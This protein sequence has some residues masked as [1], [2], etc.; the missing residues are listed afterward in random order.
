[1]NLNTFKHLGIVLLAGI[2]VSSCNTKQKSP[3]TGW[4]Y[5]DKK[6]GGFQVFPGLDQVAG[7]GL[8]YVEG[9][10]FVMGNNEQ[11]LTY[12]FDNIERRMTV[13]SFYMDETE[14]RNIDWLEYLYWIN[15]VYAKDYP[16]VYERAL[17]DTLVWRSPLAYN[18]PYVEYYLRHPAYQDYPVVGV[19]WVQATEFAAWR[20]DRVNEQ[21]LINKGILKVN[22][23]QLNE[24]NFST[25]SYLLGQ[26][27]GLVKK[28]LPELNPNATEKTRPVRMADGILQPAYRLPTEAEWEYAAK[29]LRGNSFYEN[30]NQK[31][32]YPWNG[33]STRDPDPASQ[34]LMLA[35]FKR[36]RGDNMGTAGF[37]NDNADVTAPVKSYLPNDFGLFNMAGN[38]NEWVLDVYRP[39]SFEDVNDFNAYRGNV[40]K[41]KLK[42]ADGNIAE[43]DSLGRI[44]Y[45]EDFDKYANPNKISDEDE[46]SLYDYGKA[47]L[48][49]NRAR[50]YKGGSWN[51]RAYWLSP[52]SRRFLD[53]EAS[54]ADIGFRC[55]M[56]R[57]GSPDGVAPK[58]AKPE[59][60]AKVR[61]QYKIRRRN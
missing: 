20:T 52:G 59:S 22:P 61:R 2:I 45:Q 31:R 53:E 44:K 56:I 49:N 15:R 30:V 9:G 23:N 51:D 14:V 16:Q 55:A 24:D 7:P 41:K 29:A 3:T 19:S 50:V 21:I 36:G 48:V 28:N 54:T 32:V 38:V 40:F 58:K 26:Y 60:S 13:S 17:P 10:T 18:E 27:E 37:L 1:M 6:N 11:D 39:L 47:T 5:N 34:G 43:K 46:E 35:N 12:S 42:D 33:L 8:I 25:E 57:L 4:N